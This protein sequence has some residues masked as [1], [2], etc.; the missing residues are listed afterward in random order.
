MKKRSDT[1]DP[2]RIAYEEPLGLRVLFYGPLAGF[3]LALP[4]VLYMLGGSRRD[5]QIGEGGG[6]WLALGIGLILLAA[7]IALT[8]AA[9]RRQE[10]SRNI[11]SIF[12]V[13]P[14][15]DIIVSSGSLNEPRSTLKPLQ[16]H[17]FARMGLIVNT[18]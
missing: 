18:F 16:I 7:W 1:T 5:V 10:L 11:I 13:M 9:F 2:Q 6:S 3:G 4:V 8:F 12:S 15:V 17:L 14:V